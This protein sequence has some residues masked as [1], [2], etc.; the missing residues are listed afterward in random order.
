M[1]IS[2][3]ASTSLWLSNP[4]HDGKRGALPASGLTGGCWRRH[5]RHTKIPMLH[6]I[7]HHSG[8]NGNRDGARHRID[9]LNLTPDQAKSLAAQFSDTITNCYHLGAEIFAFLA[10]VKEKCR[11]AA[12]EIA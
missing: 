3:A 4:G 7:A 5:N 10:I 9:H 8:Q 2:Q 1:Q 6:R 11:S 12:C